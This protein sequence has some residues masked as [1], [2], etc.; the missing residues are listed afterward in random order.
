MAKRLS[1]KSYKSI[2]NTIQTG[3]KLDPVAAQEVAEK[4]KEWAMEKGATHY[5]HWFQ[6]LTGTTAEKQE[7]F[8]DFSPNGFVTDFGSKQLIQGEP[9]ASSFP[10]GGLRATF[11]A[12]GY[13]GW[14][15]NSPAFIKETSKG[16]VLC[17]P[18]FFIGWHGEALDK[19][20]PLLRSMQALNKQVCRLSELFGINTKG[21]RAFATLGGEQ[22][23]FLIDRDFY[24]QRLDLIQTGRTLFGKEPAKHQQMADHYFGAIK[25][26]IVEFMEDLDRE[27][28]KAGIPAK[29]RHNE[30][31]PSQYEIAPVFEELNVAVDHNM[32]TMEIMQR[33]AEKHGLVCLLHEKP[34]AGVNGSGKHNNWSIVGPDGKNWLSPGQNPHENEKFL[35]TLC[36]VIKAV[37]SNAALLRSAVA[38]AGNDHRLGSHEAPPAIISIFLGEQL[39]H[40]VEQIEKGDLKETKHG[41]TLH[42]GIDS[43]PELP[44]DATD[45]NR[46]SPFAFTGSKFEFRAVGSNFSLAGP[47]IV[48]NLIVADAIADI[49]DQLEADKKA[50]KDFNASVEKVVRDIIKK[51]K[52][53]IFNGDNYTEEWVKEAEKRGLPNNRNTPAALSAL[54]TPEAANLFEKHGVLTKRE[55]KS[56]YDIYMETY[57]SILKYEAALA[58]DMVRTMYL[59]AVAGYM[60]SLAETVKA[61]ESVDVKTSA[62]KKTLAEVSKLNDKALDQVEKLEKAVSSGAAG[63]DKKELMEELRETIDALEA[64]VTKDAWPVPSYAEMLF[65]L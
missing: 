35:V 52:R 61:V 29:T 45:R 53:V 34:F 28:W 58:V 17:I 47:N 9:D 14:D 21:K 48:L 11:E 23:Y 8:L 19:K 6:P 16:A 62:V 56:R 15:P 18:T 31:A 38:S 25:T 7:A 36:A 42:L 49:C 30:V 2:E 64:L 65:M 44:R 10:S 63:L 33:I 39:T 3:G 12:R 32:L 59:P 60:A 26:R 22:E 50:K 20:T 46:T 24:Y 43:L 41:G 4:M 13:T 37:D 1:A 51:H 55:L 27:L 5:C 40:I 54:N 57:E